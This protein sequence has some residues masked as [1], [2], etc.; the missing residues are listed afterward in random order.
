MGASRP[1]TTGDETCSGIDPRRDPAFCPMANLYL[2][3][4]DIESSAFDLDGALVCEGKMK[5]IRKA[6]ATQR[7]T[8][9]PNAAPNP[10]VQQKWQSVIADA[11]EQMA[12]LRRTIEWAKQYNRNHQIV[13]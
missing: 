12:Q 13:L 3:A 6:K 4:E 10:H 9:E 1:A 2:S 5:R 7:K 11:E 8:A